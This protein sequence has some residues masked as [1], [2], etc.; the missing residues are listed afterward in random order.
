MSITDI[1]ESLYNKKI[2]NSYVSF[3]QGCKLGVTTRHQELIS[4]KACRLWQL[5]CCIFVIIYN[6][7]PTL[8]KNQQYLLNLC[9]RY[10]NV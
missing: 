8:I 4:T 7:N 2:I 9:S 3:L 1:I 10:Y 6:I 5:Q